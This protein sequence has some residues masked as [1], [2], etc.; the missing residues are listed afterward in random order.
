MFDKPDKTAETPQQLGGF[1]RG[2]G[3]VCYFLAV[4][5][6]VLAVLDEV[7]VADIDRYGSPWVEHFLH[8]PMWTDVLF[9]LVFALN[10]VGFT[11]VGAWIK[12]HPA[13]PA[14]APRP[15]APPPPK[16]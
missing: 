15:E 11:R 1:L 16:T 9:F 5:C 4:A 14:A 8:R 2:M 13:T 6:A 3:F 12:G 7:A 10:G